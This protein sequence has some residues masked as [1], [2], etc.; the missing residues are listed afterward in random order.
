MEKPQF[1]R[2]LEDQFFACMNVLLKWP[3]KAKILISKQ[4]KE[5]NKAAMMEKTHNH[6]YPENQEK[7]SI[8]SFSHLM[9]LFY[10]FILFNPTFSWISHS[11]YIQMNKSIEKLHLVS[12]LFNFIG[13]CSQID[14]IY[15]CCLFCLYSSFLQFLPSI[16][17]F[18]H[19]TMHWMYFMSIYCLIL[20]FLGVLYIKFYMYFV[21]LYFSVSSKRESRSEINLY[22]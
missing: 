10:S 6:S 8:Y 19:K 16:P 17:F 18:P 12:T 15:F 5:N 11:K 1:C 2:S 3:S 20:V 4:I 9:H 14:A 7:S 22:L 13:N 21:Y